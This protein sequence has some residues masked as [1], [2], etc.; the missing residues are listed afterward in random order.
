[1][2]IQSIR[3]TL[4][5]SVTVA[6]LVGL[7]AVPVGSVLAAVPSSSYSS[8]TENISTNRNTVLDAIAQ[9]KIALAHRDTR[10][11]SDQVERAEVALLNLEELHHNPDLMAALRRV[12]AARQILEQGGDLSTAGQQLAEATADL[13]IAFALG[14]PGRSPGVAAGP[15]VGVV[16]YD[17]SGQQIGPVTTV[18]FGPNGDVQRVVIRVAPGEKYVSAPLSEMSWNQNRVTLN[19]SPAQIE[20]DATYWPAQAGFGSS[21]PP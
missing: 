3:P 14:I 9:A 15:P 2:R 20:Q 10:R 7:T 6:A 13:N 11:A 1:M 18:V 8:T 19:E 17:A 12:E 4:L 21:T 16:V 5:A